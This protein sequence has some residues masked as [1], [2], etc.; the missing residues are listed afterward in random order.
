[1]TQSGATTQDQS[2]LGSDDNKGVLRNPQGSSITETLPSDCLVL[3]PGHSLEE[4][5][6]SAEKQSVYSTTPA[7]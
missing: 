6:L 5:N 1:M 7:A 3:Y 2:G 4:S